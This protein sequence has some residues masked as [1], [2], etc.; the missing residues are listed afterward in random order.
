MPLTWHSGML[1]EEVEDLICGSF[2]RVGV[3]CFLNLQVFVSHS[4]FLHP[5]CPWT[6]PCDRNSLIVNG[7]NKNDGRV[8]DPFEDG[9]LMLRGYRCR[10]GRNRCPDLLVFD[11]EIDRAG[12]THGLACNVDT[13]LVDVEL[14][15]HKS[16]NVHDI[17]F[18]QFAE[19]LRSASGISGAGST[20]GAAEVI[21]HRRGDDVSVLFCGCDQRSNDGGGRD[22]GP[23]QSYYQRVLLLRV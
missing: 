7:V 12:P 16:E 1:V 20:E 3:T 14:G 5:R 13:I 4:Q 10:R 21:A 19:I 8:P 15:S 17:L 18:T 9:W 23:V 22:T 6:N 11:T 2:E